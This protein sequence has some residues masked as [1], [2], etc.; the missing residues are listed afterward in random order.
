MENGELS[1]METMETL[2]ELGDELTLGDI[3]G[4]CARGGRSS[5]PTIAPLRYSNRGGKGR[6]CSVRTRPRGAKCR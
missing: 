2:T 4:E 1:S 3:D 5:V 6:R